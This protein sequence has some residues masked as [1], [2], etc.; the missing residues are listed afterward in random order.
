M[1]FKLKINPFLPKLKPNFSSTRFIG[2]FSMGY[3]VSELF[4]N[5]IPQRPIFDIDWTFLHWLTPLFGTIGISLVG[6]IGYHEGSFII[7]L[8]VS[9]VAYQIRWFIADSS[10]WLPCTVVAGAFT[11]ENYT[12]KWKRFSIKERPLRK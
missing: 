5:A 2:M 1:G 12:K 9:F 8:L 6:H 10:I 4:F 3:L 11:F 7:P